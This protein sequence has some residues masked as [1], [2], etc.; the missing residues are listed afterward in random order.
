[1][2]VER[3]P[4]WKSFCREDAVAVEL[5][6]LLA[7]VGERRPFEPERV[8]PCANGAIGVGPC[9]V[10]DGVP[11]FR[12]GRSANCRIEIDRFG[13]G[14]AGKVYPANPE[15]V[16]SVRCMRIVGHSAAPS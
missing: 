14:V 8:V 13:V 3:G 5:G 10:V 2:R 16:G 1:M 15:S 7:C 4:V 6:A 9:L 12:R 11:D